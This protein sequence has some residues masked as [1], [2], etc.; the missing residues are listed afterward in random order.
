MLIVSSGQQVQVLPFGTFWNFF[1]TFSLLSGSNP[2]D[3]EPW[4]QRALRLKF[5]VQHT[6]SYH[7]KGCAK[8][9]QEGLQPHFL[10]LSF[11]T[12]L[13]PRSLF[14]SPF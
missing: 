4:I 3:A 2:W 1:Q 10:Q 7:L 5:H 14:D 11:Q 6:E 9:S 13:Y 8:V 12:L